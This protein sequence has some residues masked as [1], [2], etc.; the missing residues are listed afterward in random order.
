MAIDHMIEK[1][2]LLLALARE[3]HFG[4][5]AEAAS[6]SFASWSTRPPSNASQPVAMSSC[7]G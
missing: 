5:A 1:L 4:R 6:E 3:R 2:E 7:E